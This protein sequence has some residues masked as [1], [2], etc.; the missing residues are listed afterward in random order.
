M[1]NRKEHP[2]SWSYSPENE[3]NTNWGIFIII[4][5]VLLGVAVFLL[6]AIR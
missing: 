5:S 3:A 6:S 2:F 4:A 1:R